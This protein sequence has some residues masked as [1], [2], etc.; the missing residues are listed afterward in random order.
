[1]PSAGRCIDAQHSFFMR[2][3][4]FFLLQKTL[5]MQH[6]FIYMC[7]CACVCACACMCGCWRQCTFVFAAGEALE[8]LADV[9]LESVAR[10]TMHVYTEV[11]L[12]TPQLTVHSTQQLITD[13]GESLN[14]D[15][16]L[17]T[18]THS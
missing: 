2:F 3:T 9:W 14:A 11:I 15:T 12:D 1:M 16:L 18:A 8:S 13:I 17:D 4:D 5:V 6:H 7:V 10:G